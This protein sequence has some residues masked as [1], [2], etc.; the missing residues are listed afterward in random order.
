[1][2]AQMS[3]EENLQVAAAVRGAAGFASIDGCSTAPHLANARN[4][5][6]GSLSGG[7]CEG[8]RAVCSS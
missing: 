3:V 8:A 6:A 7:G 4:V 5:P 2:L 1:M